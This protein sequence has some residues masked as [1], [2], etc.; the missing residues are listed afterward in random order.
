ME[1]A[2]CTPPLSIM[3]AQCSQQCSLAVG[4]SGELEVRGA[5]GAAVA[6]MST[7]LV[8]PVISSV[9]NIS[10]HLSGL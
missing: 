2:C 5:A 8:S 1:R 9:R 4:R 6:D 7:F 3:S 10:L